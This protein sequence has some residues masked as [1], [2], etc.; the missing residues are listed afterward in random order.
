MVHPERIIAALNEHGVQYIVIGGIAATLHGCP[1]QTFDL[2]I[3]YADTPANLA[4]LRQALEAVGAQWD[5]PLSEEVLQR[6]PVFALNTRHGDL[7]IFRW[8][9][10][11]GDFNEAALQVEQVELGAHKVLVLSLDA[12]IATKEAAADPNPRKQS[13]LAFL[14]ALRA[15]RGR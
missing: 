11:A 12:L 7:A 14:R 10:G 13:A 8:L 4:R 3:L 6:Q 1:E 5:S 15:R 9:P 2:D